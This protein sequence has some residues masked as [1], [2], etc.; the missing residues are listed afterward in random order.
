MADLEE[1]LLPD[2]PTWRIWLD[3]HHMQH[4]GVW[5]VLHK[6]G[7]STTV[8]TYA[9]A[10]EE[11]LCYGWIDGQL[12]RRDDESYRQRFTPRRPR[13]VWSARNVELVERLLEEGRMQSAGVAAV[14]RAKAQGSWDR[15]YQGQAQ[16]E[17]PADLRDA[18]NADPAALATFHQMNAVNRYAII[19]RLNAV[20]RPETRARKLS[21][22]VDMLARG[23]QLHPR[24]DS[25]AQE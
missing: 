15:A 24:R 4:P 10:L 1:L 8:L 21:E 20:K 19:Y 18:L 5:L 11:A 22:Y 7:G 12:A 6:K 2:A 9:Q 23:E 13:S 14:E 17:V 25:K 3:Q 16:M